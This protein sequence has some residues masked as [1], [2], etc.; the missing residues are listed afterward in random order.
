MRT[1]RGARSGRRR[2]V[3]TWILGASGGAGAGVATLAM[4]AAWDHNP[5]GAYHDASGVHWLDLGVV[6]L[7]WFIPVA[8][9]TALAVTALAVVVRRLR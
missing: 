7:A 3:G 2:G 8:V 5:Q 6:G 1:P 4:R 9:A